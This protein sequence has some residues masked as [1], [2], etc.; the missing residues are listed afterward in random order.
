MMNLLYDYYILR[1]ICMLDRPWVVNEARFVVSSVLRYE[2]YISRYIYFLYDAWP[3]NL[4]YHRVSSVLYY[5]SNY[6]LNY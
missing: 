2:L 6:G 4:P 5:S 1:Y 3:L